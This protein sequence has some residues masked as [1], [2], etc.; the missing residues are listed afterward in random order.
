M[1]ENTFRKPT[2]QPNPQKPI[3]TGGGCKIKVRR[4]SSGRISGYE[5]NGLCSS[6]QIKAF[7]ESINS[8]ESEQEESDD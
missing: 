3:K 6:S 5:D 2:I 1:F 8:D 7:T 4:D